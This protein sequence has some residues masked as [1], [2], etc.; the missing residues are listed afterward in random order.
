LRVLPNER[1]PNPSERGPNEAGGTPLPDSKT[2]Q[3]PVIRRAEV[4]A[5]A[6]VALLVICVVAVLYAAKAFFLPVVMAFVV[7]TMLSPAAGFLERHH[8]PRSVSAVLLVTAAGAA[9]AFI[10]EQPP[11]GIGI[12]AEG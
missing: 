2:E 4:V 1:G 3:P 10:V 5:F 8:I 12:A 6:L 11:A 9:A 7:G